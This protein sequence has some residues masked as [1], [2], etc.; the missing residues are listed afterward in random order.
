MC[1]SW[2]PGRRSG[3][4]ARRGPTLPRSGRRCDA[5]GRGMTT[6]MGRPG[7][8]E[9]GEGRERRG[10]AEGSNTATLTAALMSIR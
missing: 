1:R 4:V 8:A 5:R 9:A 10:F 7:G 6:P 2:S 3:G